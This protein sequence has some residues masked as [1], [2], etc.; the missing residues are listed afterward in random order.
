MQYRIF[1][2]AIPCEQELDELNKFLSNHRITSVQQSVVRANE[3]PT[4]VFVVEYVA[5]QA[6]KSGSSKI[7]YREKLTEAQFTVFSR[8]RDLRKS[9]A[10]E[11]G[12]PVYAV[13]T[14]AQLADI[15]QRN[16]Q[17]VQELAQTAGLGKSRIEK[18]GS[19]VISVL[20]DVS[21]SVEPKSDVK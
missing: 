17:T 8:L 6:A 12:V 15:V 9:I 13:F 16:V 2:Y 20:K 21:E 14:N 7:D 5:E 4:L 3:A 19:Q 18:Y 10:G 11:E 1:Q